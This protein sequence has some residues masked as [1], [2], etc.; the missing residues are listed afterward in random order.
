MRTSP[1]EF[2]KCSLSLSSKRWITPAATWPTSAAL[3]RG[4]MSTSVAHCWHHSR[5][6][7]PCRMTR[8]RSVSIVIRTVLL[9]AKLGS[10]CSS[11][12]HFRGTF[13][14][15]VLAYFRAPPQRERIL[16][17]KR[18]ECPQGLLNKF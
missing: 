16:L 14:V 11:A 6:D 7:A 3:S 13:P 18:I 17:E 9:V 2:D 1:L 5:T 12:G 4:T 15:N 8:S 10:H